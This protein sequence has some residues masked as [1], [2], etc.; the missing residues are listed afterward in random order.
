[1]SERYIDLLARSA[2]LHDIGKVGIPDYILLKPGKLTPEEWAIMQTHSRLGSDAIEQAERDI[3]TPLPFL[4][5]AKDLS[6]IHI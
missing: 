2:P 5:A 1:M 3:E 4:S 6:L